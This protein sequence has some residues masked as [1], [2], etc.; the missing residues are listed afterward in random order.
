MLVRTR[1]CDTHLMKTNGM[2]THTADNAGQAC[3]A[4]V[5]RTAQN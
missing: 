1:T 2:G 5:A 4:V 3:P